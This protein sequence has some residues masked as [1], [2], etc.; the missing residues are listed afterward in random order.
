MPLEQRD[1][2]GPEPSPADL[3]LG[4]YAVQPGRFKL[5]SSQV[6][7]YERLYDLEADP[8]EAHDVASCWPEERA[9][10]RALGYVD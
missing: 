10:L 1:S 2:P 6:P 8:R 5:V 7:R 4:R 9:R 3:A